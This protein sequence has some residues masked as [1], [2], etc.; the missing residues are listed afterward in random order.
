MLEM[1]LCIFRLIF[2]TFVGLDQLS[3]VLF[4]GVC[5]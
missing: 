2:L 5:V 3:A 4:M 1:S